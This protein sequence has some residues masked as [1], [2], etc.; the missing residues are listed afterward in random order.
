MQQTETYKLNLI[1]SSDT[2][3]PDP[4]NENMEKAEEALDGLNQRV[5]VLETHKIVTGFHEGTG[6]VDLGFTPVV[7]FGIGSNSIGF[8]TRGRGS[9]GGLS[10]EEGGFSHTGFAANCHYAAFV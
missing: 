10:V 6:F 9:S 2:F 1:E 8:A 5:T 7:V 4:L 3:S